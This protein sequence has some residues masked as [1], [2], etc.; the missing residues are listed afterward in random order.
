MLASQTLPR[1]L[2]FVKPIHTHLVTFKPAHLPLP[3]T[4]AALRRDERA[5][6]QR[7]DERNEAERA[8]VM[9]EMEEDEIMANV[10][11]ARNKTGRAPLNATPIFCICAGDASR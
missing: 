1:S 8:A 11:Q 7:A 9:G 6:N 2:P 4:T 10:S 3:C 5:S